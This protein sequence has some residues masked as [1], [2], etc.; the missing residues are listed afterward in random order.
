MRPPKMFPAVAALVV[1]V[2]SVFAV[3]TMP[4]KNR[5]DRDSATDT[6]TAMCTPSNQPEYV[7]TKISTKQKAKIVMS[8]LASIY[9]VFVILARGGGGGS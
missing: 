1:F 9:A 4:D 3:G 2:V 7:S 5:D 6:V 8:I